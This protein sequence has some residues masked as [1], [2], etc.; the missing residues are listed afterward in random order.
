MEVPD[1]KGRLAIL[2]VHAKNKKLSEDVE[3]AQIAMRTPGFSGA[4][5]ANLLNE[6][7]KFPHICLPW[8]RSLSALQ[9]ASSGWPSVKCHC[10]DASTLHVCLQRTG[11]AC[12]SH[13]GYLDDRDEQTP[14]STGTQPPAHLVIT[15]FDDWGREGG[16]CNELALNFPRFSTCKTKHVT[17]SF[18]CRRPS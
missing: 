18:A 5:L 17:E 13:W 14:Q 8:F 12:L 16:S 9:P 3:L 6:V 4:D 7:S 2:K 15:V 10:G 11:I 1:Q